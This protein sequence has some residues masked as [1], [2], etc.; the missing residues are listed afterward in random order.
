MGD[1]E[2][3]EKGEDEGGGDVEVSRASDA[4][5]EWNFEDEDKPCGA[6]KSSAGHHGT[7]ARAPRGSHGT[8]ARAPRDSHG[9]MAREPRDSSSSHGLWGSS[10]G[11]SRHGGKCVSSTSGGLRTSLSSVARRSGGRWSLLNGSGGGGPG[12]LKKARESGVLENASFDGLSSS[13]SSLMGGGGSSIMS[14]GGGGAGRSSASILMFDELGSVLEGRGEE[15]EDEGE[16]GVEIMAVEGGDFGYYSGGLVSV[17]EGIDDCEDDER[18]GEED[19]DGRDG[20]AREEAEREDQEGQGG[21][22]KQVE[23]RAGKVEKENETDKKE[24]EE[25][26]EEE[27]EVDKGE[28]AL[29]LEALA[30]SLAAALDDSGGEVSSALRSRLRVSKSRVGSIDIGSDCRVFCHGGARVR[31]AEDY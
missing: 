5:S 21:V 2:E 14:G 9:T 24:G 10:G 18:R 27:E 29:L 26:E 1:G 23:G 13:S 22:K 8:M 3:S 17:L 4:F 19:K 16:V 20:I 11:A 25:G 28:A 6:R 30:P 12:G 31:R 15:E 7:L